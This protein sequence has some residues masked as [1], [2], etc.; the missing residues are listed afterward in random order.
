MSVINLAWSAVPTATKYTVYRS[1]VAGSIG[2]SIGE[3]TV[4]AFTDA[5]AVVGTPYWYAVTASNAT[6]EGPASAQAQATIPVPLPVPD[7]P[8]NLTAT[9]V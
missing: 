7:A 2:L 3:V 5:T 9:V 8:T 6:G 1:T 4:T